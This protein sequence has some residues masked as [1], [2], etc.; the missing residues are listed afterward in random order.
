M[1]FPRK[2][3]DKAWWVKAGLTREHDFVERVLPGLGIEARMN[4]A[5]EH[6]PFTADLLVQG[7]LADLK[8]QRAPFFTAKKFRAGTQWLD[9]QWT[10]TFNRNDYERYTE[11]YPNIEIFFWVD[12]L[13]P[14]KEGVPWSRWNPIED[15][16]ECVSPLT[17]VWATTLIAIRRYVDTFGAPLHAYQQRVDDQRGNARESY[18]FD[19]RWMNYLKGSWR[20]YDYSWKEEDGAEAQAHA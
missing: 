10:V 2:T 13:P 11:R 15:Y 19:L 17:G 12:W 6:N 20:F 7:R 1:T 3:E 14:K 5:K 16:G 9:P 4:P 8:C 18:L